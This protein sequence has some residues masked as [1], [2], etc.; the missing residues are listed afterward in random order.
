MRSICA[1]VLVAPLAL[2]LGACG[3]QAEV[4]AAPSGTALTAPVASPS[5][6]SAV[7]RFCL[8]V[9]EYAQKI[10]ELQASPDPQGDE[11]LRAKAQELQD[12]AA[13]LTQELM[14]DPT[15]AERVERCTAALQ[16]ALAQPVQ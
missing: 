5:P 6:T 7:D 12:S 14:D 9:D 11:Q 10:Q 15:Q 2:G 1:A 8:Q 16:E 13:Q 3:G 4:P